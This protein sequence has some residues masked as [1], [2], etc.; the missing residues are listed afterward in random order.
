MED[1]KPLIQFGQDVPDTNEAQALIVTAVHSGDIPELT[2]A[3]AIHGF[4]GWHQAQA[5]A[6]KETNP[7]LSLAFVRFSHLSPEQR[8]RL[9]VVKSDKSELAQAIK[10]LR[11]KDQ[12]GEFSEAG[13]DSVDR[14]SMALKEAGLSASEKNL[15]AV[16]LAFEDRGLHPSLVVAQA[17]NRKPQGKT[18]ADRVRVAVQTATDQD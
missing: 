12:S 13:S 10:Q 1:S 14:A 2:E 11:L 16:S 17:E 8:K 9:L 6:F 5:E 4:G 18:V 3:E 15:F 7:E